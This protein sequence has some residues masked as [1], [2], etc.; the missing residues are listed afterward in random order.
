MDANL[1]QA[2]FT[3]ETKDMNAIRRSA[4]PCVS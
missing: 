4:C 3:D 1:L 2:I